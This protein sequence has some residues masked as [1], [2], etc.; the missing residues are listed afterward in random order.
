MTLE[1]RAMDRGLLGNVEI[2]RPFDP[3]TIARICAQVLGPNEQNGVRQAVQNES[4]EVERFSKILADMGYAGD[5]PYK[6]LSWLSYHIGRGDPN[7]ANYFTWAGLLMEGN[8]DVF[9]RIRDKMLSVLQTHHPERLDVHPELQRVLYEDCG[10]IHFTAVR[11]PRVTLSS[12][13]RH[14]RVEWPG[15]LSGTVGT[16]PAVVSFIYGG[17][18]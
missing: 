7:C 15:D 13:E 2:N 11:I 17:N 9:V 5:S 3:L 6:L 8:L 4:E 18:E 14:L 10:S 1:V 16:P 12:D